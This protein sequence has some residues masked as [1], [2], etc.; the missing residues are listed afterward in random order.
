MDVSRRQVLAA[1]A[2]MV[3]GASHPIPPKKRHPLSLSDRPRA[4]TGFASF[5]DFTEDV[6]CDA[7]HPTAIRA[8]S[9]TS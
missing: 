2:G 6:T 4:L 5:E 8:A 1:A 9:P 3:L 7:G